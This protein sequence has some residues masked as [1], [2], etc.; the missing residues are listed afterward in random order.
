MS[1]TDLLISLPPLPLQIVPSAHSLF[2]LHSTSI[3]PGVQGK[4]LSLTV[5]IQPISKSCQLHLQNTSTHHHFHCY[6]PGPSHCASPEL[7]LLNHCSNRSPPSACS[8]E[9]SESLDDITPDPN[10]LIAS[11]PALS[12]SQ[13]PTWSHSL[14]PPCPLLA[15]SLIIYSILITQAF[16][17]SIPSRLLQ[18]F[19]TFFS[20]QIT[21]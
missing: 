13:G 5:H 21:A 9:H 8:A 3:H 4:L 17:L 19:S 11:P 1:K 16:L 10:Y 20:P 2:W 14:L 15:T 6:H 18:D 7:F 12:K